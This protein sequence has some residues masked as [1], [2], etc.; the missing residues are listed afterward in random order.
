MPAR[1]YLFYVYILANR[2]R[3]LYIG[4]T[5]NL[6][7]RIAQ[8]REHRPGTYTARYNIDRLVYYEQFAYILNAVARET[9]LKD[10]NRTEKIVLIEQQNPTWNDLAADW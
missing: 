4:L 7:T 3:N 9:E 2:S 6:A 1:E 5:N 8:H 10:W